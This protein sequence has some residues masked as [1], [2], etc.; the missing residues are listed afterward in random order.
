MAIKKDKYLIMNENEEILVFTYKTRKADRLFLPSEK[1]SLDEEETE[2]IF[3]PLL[4][5]LKS[6]GAI[7]DDAIELYTREDYVDRLKCVNTKL[8]KTRELRIT[9]YYLSYCS[10]DEEAVRRINE[11]CFD[12]EIMPL[13]LPSEELE[14]ILLENSYYLKPENAPVRLD[15]FI[16]IPIQRIK[17]YKGEILC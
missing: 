4:S 14:R 5:T 11:V 15:K 17:G 13:F 10:L 6:V 2:S 12:M 7:S 8:V 1:R 9:N 3:D 16:S